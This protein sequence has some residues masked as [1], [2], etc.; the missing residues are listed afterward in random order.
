M[1]WFGDKTFSVESWRLPELGNPSWRP[2]K[3]YSAVF[4]IASLAFFVRL[5]TE[6]Q[7]RVR[8]LA[9]HPMLGLLN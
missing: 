7:S 3:K 2:K 6:R 1:L 8:I 9:Q 5:Q 4:F